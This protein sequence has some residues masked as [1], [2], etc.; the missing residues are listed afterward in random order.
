MT[1]AELIEENWRELVSE[2][3]EC[4]ESVYRSH[5]K[6]RYAIYCSKTDGVRVLEDVTGGDLDMKQPGYSLITVID[7][8]YFD[9]WDMVDDEERPEDEWAAAEREDEVIIRLIDSTN[10]E[11]MLE[12]IQENSVFDEE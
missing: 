11:E 12:E 7:H 10:W 4:T 8:P 6:V 2:L 3:R 5:G 9:P 1:K